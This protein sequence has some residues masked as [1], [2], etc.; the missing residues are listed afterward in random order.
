MK[1]CD[2]ELIEYYGVC[3]TC[4]KRQARTLGLTEKQGMKVRKCYPY[5]LIIP[6]TEAGAHLATVKDESYSNLLPP[7]KPISE[8]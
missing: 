7:D 3:E 1:H 4:R 5:S 6:K 8:H 2:R